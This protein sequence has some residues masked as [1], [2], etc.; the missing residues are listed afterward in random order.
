MP[1]ISFDFRCAS[2][3]D[4]SHKKVVE[5]STGDKLIDIIESLARKDEYV[6]NFIFDTSEMRLYPYHIIFAGD[7]LLLPKDLDNYII[8][9]GSIY[10]RV[11]PFVS[12]G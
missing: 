1:Q 5:A 11:L 6:S 12:G 10:I 4:E 9:E 8:N 3:P 2:A 7:E